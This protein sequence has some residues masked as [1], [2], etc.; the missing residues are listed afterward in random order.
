MFCGYPGEL[1]LVPIVFLFSSV[2]FRSCDF[3]KL[4]LF[5]PLVSVGFFF[6]LLNI[7]TESCCLS[8]T[9][10]ALH[11]MSN[12]TLGGLIFEFLT[13]FGLFISKLWSYSRN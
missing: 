13:L 10:D 11:F 2:A 7:S 8:F 6:I 3:N 4:K 1:D 5:S 9:L 12:L